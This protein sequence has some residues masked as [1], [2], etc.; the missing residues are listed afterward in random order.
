V[1]FPVAAQ[2]ADG[3]PVQ[4]T[5][6]GVTPVGGLQKTVMVSAVG[7]ILTTPTFPVTVQ[8]T[9]DD[10]LAQVQTSTTVTGVTCS[11]L[12]QVCEL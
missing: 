9:I 3:D 7:G 5:F 12:G 8:V 2:E 11:T 6:S 1:P 4:V 10:G